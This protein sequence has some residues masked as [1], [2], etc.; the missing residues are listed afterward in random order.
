MTDATTQKPLHVLRD[1]I[2]GP[3]LLLSLDQLDDVKRL[4]DRNGVIYEVESNAISLNNGPFIIAIN[5]G[6]K[7]DAERVQTILDG[8]N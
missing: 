5:F 3:Y 6:R 2:A 1:E 8:A 7:G 4:L